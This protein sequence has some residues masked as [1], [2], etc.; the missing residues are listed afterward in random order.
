MSNKREKIVGTMLQ[1][2]GVLIKSATKI[3]SAE[4]MTKD[5]EVDKNGK[6]SITP[7][8]LEKLINKAVSKA[9]D[10]DSDSI[11][12][13]EEN[14]EKPKADLLGKQ[15]NNMPKDELTLKQEA[16]DKRTKELMDKFGKKI[17]Y[18]EA[19]QQAS[20]EIARLREENKETIEP[21]P[22]KSIIT[23]PNKNGLLFTRLTR[24]K[25]K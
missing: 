7:Q 8:D 21:K 6:I 24:K 13:N 23:V 3:E 20:W 9:L 22:P 11:A 10:N 25:Y 15:A 1:P 14:E 2:Q 17:T 16:I 19:A 5:L 4:D 18:Q 12:K